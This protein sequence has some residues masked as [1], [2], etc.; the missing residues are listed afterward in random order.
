MTSEQRDEHW[1][2]PPDQRELSLHGDIVMQWLTSHPQKND[3][4]SY[5]EDIMDELIE[6]IADVD[7]KYS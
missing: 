5:K 6:M 3:R 7:P 1:R 4:P 2:Q